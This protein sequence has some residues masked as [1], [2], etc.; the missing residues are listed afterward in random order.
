MLEPFNA[1]KEYHKSII[2]AAAAG[3]PLRLRVLLPRSF[4]VTHV[5][6]VI[7]RDER[8]DEYRPMNWESTDNV[9]EWWFID[10]AFDEPGAYFYRFEYDTAWGRTLIRRVGISQSG[11]IDGGGE[12]EQFVYPSDMR[13][14][15]DFDGGIFYQIFPDR[16][17]FSGHKKEN[18]PTDRVIR[19]DWGGMPVWEPDENGT[20]RNNDYFCGDFDG[21]TEKLP[22]IASLGV[23]CVY[24]NPICEA[25]SNHRYDTANYMRPD[26]LLGTD[27]D[28]KKLCDTA[29]SLGM[30]ILIDGVYSHTGADSVYFNKNGRYG[31][32]GAYNDENSPYRQ[33]Y[34]FGKDR[35]EYKG[36]WNFKTLPEVNETNPVFAEFITGTDG[37]IN[38]WLS[39]GADGIRLDVADELPD[40]F[41][42]KIRAAVKRHGEDKMLLGEVWEDASCKISQ[43]GR[44]RYFCGSELDSVMNYPFRTAINDFLLTSNARL[45]MDRIYSV[46]LNYPPKIMNLCMNFLGTHDT[47]RI[48]T[49]LTGINCDDM[50]RLSQSR[51]EYSPETLAHAKKLLRAAVSMLYTLPGIPCIYYGD[52][53]GLTGGKDPFNRAC[54]PWGGEDNDI[55]G[56]HKML[57]AFRKDAK[58]LSDGGFYPLSSELGCAAYLRYK[59]GERRV[60]CIANKNPDAIDYV[61]NPDM[62]NMHAFCGGEN[63]GGVVRIPSETVCI[64]TD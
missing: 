12:W 26:P 24:L 28:F 62:Q 64:L 30:K 20:V 16:F 2:G 48:L 19:T 23:T 1:A 8:P 39:L 56:F 60:A 61:L 34:S 29:H 14:P 10:T 21:I 15:D 63:F 18:V 32:G 7:T 22:Y 46:Y 17:N 59:Q 44:R 52:E 36:W 45:F 31:S 53:A 13:T 43:G 55:I 5:D 11:S 41:I 37:V 51:L 54:Y 6:L 33:W 57:G 35:D 40:T 25:H 38:R 49:V 42:E 27:A 4:R 9:N 50:S 58:V 47:Q 3:T